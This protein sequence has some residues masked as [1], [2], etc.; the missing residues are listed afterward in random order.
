MTDTTFAAFAFGALVG[1][2]G[3]LA[4]AYRGN[5][6]WRIERRLPGR[7]PLCRRWWSRKRMT[8]A[9]HRTAGHVYICDECY[10]D[11]YQ[12]FSRHNEPEQ[13]HGYVE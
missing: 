13:E 6:L 2:A 4:Y 12:P 8:F 1:W 9:N 10:A 5:L 7:C 11:E 3:G